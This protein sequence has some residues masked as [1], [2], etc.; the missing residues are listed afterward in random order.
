MR[1]VLSKKPRSIDSVV[2]DH[3]LCKDLIEDARKFLESGKWYSDLGIPYR[4]GYLLYGPPGCGKT[5]FCQVLAGAL[6]LDVCILSL[7]NKGMDD[8]GLA[9]L[10]RDAPRHSVVILE[11]VD[12]VFANRELQRSAGDAAG[13]TFS[14]LLNAIDGVAS[15]EGR[16]FMMTTNHI[17]RL[18]PALIRPGRC[19]VRVLVSNA[20]RDQMA[21][22][23]LR[24]FPGREEDARRFA[25]RLPPGELSMAQIQGHLVEHKGSPAAAVEATLSLLHSARPTIDP[26]VSVW[27]H[28]RRLGLEQYAA[29]FERHGYAVKEDLQG[30]K[31]DRA[32]GWSVELRTNLVRRAPAQPARCLT[33]GQRGLTERRPGSAAPASPR[34]A[35]APL[36]GRGAEGAARRGSP[37]GAEQSRRRG[38]EAWELGCVWGG[39]VQGEDRLRLGALPAPAGREPAAGEAAG[40]DKQGGAAA[41]ASCTDTGGGGP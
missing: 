36:R 40:R 35:R 24:F 29:L 34:C 11:D 32:A 20:S 38:A 31:A 14:G 28:L 22:M 41:A 21:G 1:Q 39:N 2:L 27:Q 17:E 19:D 9:G 15:Q 33:R 8:N 26:P 23:F 4:R 13:I 37:A 16:L 3:G 7:S 18:D 10:M 6:R 25:G 5:S 30:L 12:A